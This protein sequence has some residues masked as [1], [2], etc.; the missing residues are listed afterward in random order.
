MDRDMRMLKS[1]FMSTGHNTLLLC[2]CVVCV[3]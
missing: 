1:I 3:Y 2:V